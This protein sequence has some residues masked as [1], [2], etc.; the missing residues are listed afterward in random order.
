LVNKMGKTFKESDKKNRTP[1][2]A[3]NRSKKNSKKIPKK[4]YNK[5][6]SN[7]GD[8]DLG[9]KYNNNRD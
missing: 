1:W 9:E 5:D 4:S 8:I 7:L 6:E 3:K 2:Y